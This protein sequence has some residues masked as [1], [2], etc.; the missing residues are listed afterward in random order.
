VLYSESYGEYTVGTK[1]RRFLMSERTVHAV[2]AGPQ[3]VKLNRSH[4]KIELLVQNYFTRMRGASR[5]IHRKVRANSVTQPK[6]CKT[7][8]F[9][10]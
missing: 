7:F 8:P 10:G 2:T 1:C 9:D 6:N 3:Q 4:I 5:T